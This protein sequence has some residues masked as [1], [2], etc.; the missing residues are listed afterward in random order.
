[1]IS[2]SNVFPSL[3][4]IS[5][6]PLLIDYRHFFL[7]ILKLLTRAFLNNTLLLPRTCPRSCST[8][9]SNPPCYI[10]GAKNTGPLIRYE[11]FS[12]KSLRPNPPPCSFQ[13]IIRTPYIVLSYLCEPFLSYHGTSRNPLA[14][15]FSPLTYCHITRP[16]ASSGSM[17]AFGLLRHHHHL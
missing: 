11:P 14:Q 17:M 2:F 1:M 7:R 10:T 5:L 9:L 12:C 8:L 3:F 13:S 15:I 4:W 16:L 6:F